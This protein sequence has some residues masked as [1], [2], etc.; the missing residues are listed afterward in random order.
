A[1]G[2]PHRP[3]I[4]VLASE[5]FRETFLVEVADP[6]LAGLR[7]LVAL[8]PPRFALA[9]EQQ[10]LAIG[11]ECP[12]GTVVIKE[13]L[14]GG[15]LAAGDSEEAIGMPPAVIAAGLDEQR[16]A[17]GRPLLQG[18]TGRVEGELFRRSA[19]GGYHVDLPRTVA[20]A[21]KGDLLAI[22]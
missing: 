13:K 12:T 19:G 8:A 11:R 16:L 9:R 21:D 17:V 20:I 15:T 1:I 5:D 6:H 10:P 2:P 4:A 14:L 3:A 22:G 7:A 18:V